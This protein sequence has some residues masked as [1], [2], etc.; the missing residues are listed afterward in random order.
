MKEVTSLK[1]ARKTPTIKLTYSKFTM[2]SLLYLAI[3]VAILFLGYLK[4]IIGIAFTLM[5][6]AGVYYAIKNSSKDKDGALNERSIEIKPLTLVILSL[7]SVFFIFYAGVG[8]FAFCTI[9][10]RVRY[11]ILKDLIDYK[12]PVIYDFS[13]Q[14]N[15]VVS[16][17]LG[18]GEVAFAYY[19]TFWMIPAIIGKLF[20]LMVA[21]VAIILWSAIGL[22]L[23]A[24]GTYFIRSKTPVFIFL[25]IILWGGWDFIPWLINTL[26]N[27]ETTFEGWNCHLH[28]HTNYYQLFNVFNQSIPG[29]LITILLMTSRNNKSIGLLGGLMFC[30]SPWA[31]VG[32]VPLCVNRLICKENISSDKKTN[33]R[34]IFSIGNL[35]AP[36]AALVVFASMY[37]AN[38]DATSS[39]GLIWKFYDAPMELV[40]DYV[41]YVVFEFGIWA[42]ILFHKYKKDSMFWTAIGTLMVLPIYKV[43]IANDFIMRGSLV[44]FFLISIYTV[45]WV[46]EQFE[47]A[48]GK[49]FSLKSRLALLALVISGFV[50]INSFITSFAL[51]IKIW[52]GTEESC[53]RDIDSFGDIKDPNQIS[54]VRT[55]FYVYNYEDSIFFKYL[56]K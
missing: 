24:I 44:P 3:P 4:P 33:I 56:A 17:I 46:S 35:L 22:L 50:A 32:M 48:L 26:T 20:G 41:W 43:S 40:K 15:P 5:V 12:W 52:Q 14:S 34:N 6:G 47:I 36:V 31:T 38:P 30:Y 49:E 54:M 16:Q 10:H 1:P 45:I 25:A 53:A 39:S 13:T 27:V 2:I 29:W 55:Q 37:T 7:L 51:S 28:V 42:L 11:A 9:D 8:E 19:F 18:E 21:R 23:V